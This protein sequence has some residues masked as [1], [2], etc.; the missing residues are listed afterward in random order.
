MAFF[1][2]QS[3]GTAELVTLTNS[4]VTSNSYTATFDLSS[5]DISGKTINDFT[6]GIKQCLS[7]SSSGHGTFYLDNPVL[8][9]NSVSVNAHWS[10]GGNGAWSIVFVCFT[11]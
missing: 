7:S 3:G 10:G 4:S 5:Y 11:Q 1:D 6:F 2:C 8:S 9:G